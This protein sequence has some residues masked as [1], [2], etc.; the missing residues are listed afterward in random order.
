MNEKQTYGDHF[1]SK[2]NFLI[3]LNRVKGKH[4][5]FHCVSVRIDYHKTSRFTSIPAQLI[6]LQ[7]TIKTGCKYNLTLQYMNTLHRDKTYANLRGH[8]TIESSTVLKT[9]RV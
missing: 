1:C 8:C 6:I 2:V 7:K 4:K 3:S 5:S 9:V